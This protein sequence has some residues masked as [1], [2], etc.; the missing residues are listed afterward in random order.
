MEVAVQNL[1][2][3]PS[4]NAGAAD[5]CHLFGT[6]GMSVLVNV[7]SKPGR[8]AFPVLADVEAEVVNGAIEA[9]EARSIFII[10]ERGSGHGQTLV[11]DRVL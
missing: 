10:V 6:N 7:R 2:D 5:G 8:D 11:R 4:G 9:V 3:D 1:V